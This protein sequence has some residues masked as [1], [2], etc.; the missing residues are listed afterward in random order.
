MPSPAAEN[1]GF[2][3]S[4]VTRFLALLRMHESILGQLRYS[5][6]LTLIMCFVFCPLITANCDRLY[7][8]MIVS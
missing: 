5:D 3:F 4:G 7:L 6:D 2:H 8:E 1:C